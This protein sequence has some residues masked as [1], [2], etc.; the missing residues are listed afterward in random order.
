MHGFIRDVI[1]QP[2][3]WPQSQLNN[4]TKGVSVSPA[5]EKWSKGVNKGDHFTPTL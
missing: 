4:I 2:C 3:Q 1:T 5:I